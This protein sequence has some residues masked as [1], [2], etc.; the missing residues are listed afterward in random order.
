MLP[1][2]RSQLP[3]WVTAHSVYHRLTVCSGARPA[4][5]ARRP[6]PVL[7]ALI[8]GRDPLAAP[9]KGQS[10][11]ESLDKQRAEMAAQQ[12]EILAQQ[13]ELRD[14]EAQKIELQRLRLEL[15]LAKVQAAASQQQAPL[16]GGSQSWQ[17]EQNQTAYQQ[18]IQPQQQHHQTQQQPQVQSLPMQH[19]QQ[20]PVRAAAKVGAHPLQPLAVTAGQR[21]VSARTLQKQQWLA[22]LEKQKQEK[23]QRQE[24]EKLAR[25]QEEARTLQMMDSY[26]P[27]GRP[28]PG[29]G[30]GHGR[31]GSQ[32]H[33]SPNRQH[34]QNSP[35][36]RA[37]VAQQ[38]TPAAVI[39]Q[40]ALVLSP[41]GIDPNSIPG[42]EGLYGGGTAPI[43][44]SSIPGL[45]PVAQ[46]SPDNGTGLDVSLPSS[47]RIMSGREN[48]AL[49]MSGT[50]NSG[51]RMCH[52]MKCCLIVL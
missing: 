29:V 39:Q 38:H 15:E 5:V 31:G 27:W 18:P 30:P 4:K 11:R 36:D 25:Q 26:N 3:D 10:V 8:D 40:P 22:D 51:Q 16:V 48:A 42:L 35:P 43:D 20:T 44:A 19:Q 23:K 34:A 41:Q 12:A 47:N 52:N 45:G 21:P 6:G 7:G 13:Q 50:L 32:A 17:P 9:R 37:V 14:L 24:A 49:S 46:H 1:L 33:Q 28:G 2:V